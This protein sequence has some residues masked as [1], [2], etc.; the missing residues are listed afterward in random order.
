[1]MTVKELI[2]ELSVLPEDACLMTSDNSGF[3]FDI[4]SIGTKVVEQY[5][6]DNTAD[7]ECRLGETVV[8]FYGS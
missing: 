8:V 5:D 6:A 3:M 1:M 4:Y 7:A 2:K